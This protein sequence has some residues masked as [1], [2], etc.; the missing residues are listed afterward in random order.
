MDSKGERN[1]SGINKGYL[2]VPLI[3][4]TSP[5]GER[6]SM[7]YLEWIDFAVENYGMSSETAHAQWVLFVSGVRDSRLHDAIIVLIDKGVK[8]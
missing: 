1:S 4:D 6:I 7:K 2:R 5:I 3:G 8:S